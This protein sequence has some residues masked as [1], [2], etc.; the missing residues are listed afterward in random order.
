MTAQI[1]HPGLSREEASS[2]AN[3]SQ[4]LVLFV[5]F[6]MYG[7][8]ILILGSNYFDIFPT[9]HNMTYNL[10]VSA[11]FLVV[12]V[13]L[14]RS[15]RWN[16]YWQVAFAFFVASVAYPVTNLS[17]GWASQV[18]KW[19][20]LMDTSSQGQ[21]IVKVCEVVSVVIPILLLTKVSGADLGSVYVKR[22][23]LRW[24]LSIGALVFFNFAAS[25]F[26]FFAT[27]FTSVGTLGAAVLWGL[28]FSFANA[29]MEELW[30]RGIFL[31]R[32][33]P[34]IGIKGSILLTSI[35][36]AL[37]HGGATYL[38]P[39]A[40]PFIVA[41]TFTLGLACSYLI[42]KTDSIWGAVLIHAASDLF[43]FIAL[44]ANA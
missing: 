25:A 35:L 10:A 3:I 4:R 11:V 7:F 29:F 44:L 37:L 43:L 26:L 24:G 31:R 30:I 5:G 41:N 16:G 9:N 14:N 36:F 15:D 12:A 33:E 22:G 18:L 21:A 19:L 13:G 39:V 32:F 20:N 38:T 28:V 17:S 34:L 23:N 27:R 1:T 40:I 42:M 2:R 8:A 6:F